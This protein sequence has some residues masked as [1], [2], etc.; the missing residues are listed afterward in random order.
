LK[1]IRLILLFYR[2]FWFASSLISLAC[3]ALFW[4]YGYSIFSTLFWF[5]IATLFIIYRYI[6]SYKAKEFYYYQNLGISKQILWIATLGADLIV[7]LLLLVQVNR[8]R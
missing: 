8:F 4:E 1:K 7:Y 2:N 3:L 6:G 5:K